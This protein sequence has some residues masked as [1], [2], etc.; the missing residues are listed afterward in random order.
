MRL[1]IILFLSLVVG[2]FSQLFSQCS[3]TGKKLSTEFLSPGFS[4]LE[5]KYDVNYYHINLLINNLDT[6]IE[7]YTDIGITAL[8][9]IDT[10]VFEL[11]DDLS[12]DS[13]NVN[14]EYHQ[15]YL[16]SDG[17][18]NI[19]IDNNI[20][21]GEKTMLRIYYKGASQSSN[22]FSG[23]SN[24]SDFIYNKSVT[25][26][27]S[28]PFQ[29]SSWFP[30]KQDLH[31]KADSVRVYLTVD[32]DL[33]AGSNG[34]LENISIPEDGKKTYEWFSNYPIAYYLISFS[35]SD[36]IDYSFNVSI[37]GVDDSLLVQNFIYNSVN[38]FENEKEN[39]D[40]T[41]D[42]LELFSSLFGTYPFINEKYGHCMAPMGGGMEHQTMT[43]LQNFNF[44]LVAHELAHQWFGDYV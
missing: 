6:Y 2:K 39:I 34:V 43:T 16:H 30:V 20:Q 4:D 36:Y 8:E 35:V 38:I 37:E 27:L 42:L 7:G 44:L 29:A 25:Y 13:I 3:H 10:I 33:M 31:D 24:R 28:E 32:E 11:L 1:I 40:K 12:I 14:S 22:F 9:V 5:K 19:A 15:N 23:I 17:L 18:I 26:T 41:G 21:V